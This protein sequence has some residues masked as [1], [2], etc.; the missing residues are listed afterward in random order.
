MHHGHQSAQMTASQRRPPLFISRALN[1]IPTHSRRLA[2]QCIEAQCPLPSSAELSANF[3]KDNPTRKRIAPAALA[4][5]PLNHTPYH[6]K[7]PH[8][9]PMSSMPSMPPRQSKH[10]QHLRIRP[11]PTTSGALGQTS[12]KGHQSWIRIAPSLLTTQSLHQ[13]PSH[14][15]S[16]IA[17]TRHPSRHSL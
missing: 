5:L 8:R 13:A 12:K 16:F 15:K 7:S 3:K 10:F 11:P 4:T 2:Q 14:T 17:S 6:A 1:T 9:L